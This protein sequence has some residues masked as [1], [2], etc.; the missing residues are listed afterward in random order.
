MILKRYCLVQPEQK[1]IMIKKVYKSKKAT[2][3]NCMR[4]HHI[5]NM[6]IVEIIQCIE[7]VFLNTKLQEGN[8]VN[9]N[10]S[11]TV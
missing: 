4:D 3:T 10:G 1:N 8:R 7:T 11:C 6:D 5:A 2:V 9:N